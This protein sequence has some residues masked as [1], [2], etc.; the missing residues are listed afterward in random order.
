MRKSVTRKASPGDGGASPLPPGAGIIRASAGLTLIEVL[1]ALFIFGVG[2][3]VIFQG[4]ALGLKVRRGADESRRLSLVAL[5]R[6]SLM[7]ADGAVS[8][9]E[10]EGSTGDYSWRIERTPYGE[11]GDQGDSGGLE[12]VRI[13]VESPSGKIWETVSLFPVEEDEP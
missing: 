9:E 7:M 3:A 4:L 2:V 8:E 13:T 6:I 12:A 10:E 11:E 1:V 5:D